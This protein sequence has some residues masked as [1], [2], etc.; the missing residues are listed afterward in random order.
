MESSSIVRTFGGAIWH[1]KLL[2]GAIIAVGL[3]AGYA[4]YRVTPPTYESQAQLYVDPGV[5]Q[6]LQQ[7]DG[8]LSRYIVQ[9]GTSY[10]VL[11]RAS[12]QLAGNPSPDDLGRRV[13]STAVKATNLVAI[14]AIA[15][16]PSGAAELA[17]TV[18][19]AVVD[20]N[21]ADSSERGLQSQ[22]YLTSELA[23]LSDVIKADQAAG[24]SAEQLTSDRQVYANTYGRL[25]DLQLRIARAAEGV[26]VIQQALPP[27]RPVNPDLVRYLAVAAAAGL[28][29]ALLIAL[30]VERFDDRVLD[31]ETVG[32]ASGTSLVVGAPRFHGSPSEELLAPYSLAYANLVAR[33]PRARTIMV[34]ASSHRESTESVAAAL[35]E[36]DELTG[37][38]TKV[39]QAEPVAPSDPGY[40]PPPLSPH[41]HL[42]DAR[43]QPNTQLASTNSAPRTFVAVPAPLLSPKAATMADNVDVAILVAISGVTRLGEVA[44]TAEALRLAGIEPVAVILLSKKSVR[45]RH[46]DWGQDDAVG[47]DDQYEDELAEPAQ[48]HLTSAEVRPAPAPYQEPRRSVNL[49]RTESVAPARSGPNGADAGRVKSTPPT[50]TPPTTVEGKALRL[51]RLDSHGDDD[52]DTDDEFDQEGSDGSAGSGSAAEVERR[53]RRRR[54]ANLA[55]EA[56]QDAVRF[57]EDRTGE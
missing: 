28:C 45:A 40:P 55:A 53:G 52:Q 8:L 5:D 2:I 21:R 57:D 43:S 17:N 46:A 13:T 20:Q 27:T 18:G 9:Q 37:N 41:L 19:K 1:R 14:T 34:V 44:H 22:T 15:S 54:R 33:Y 49:G 4:L 29:L 39:V 31:S 16:S 36:A 51:A 56:V 38:R 42:P 26:S 25:Q 6:V 12:Q 10:R 23:R 35:S 30:L 7:S 3:I 50:T 32:K 48:R 11:Q 24:A 47:V